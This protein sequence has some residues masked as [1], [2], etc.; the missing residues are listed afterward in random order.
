[1]P[2]RL[3]IFPLCLLLWLSGAVSAQGDPE[4][5]PLAAQASNLLAYIAVDYA[6]AVQDG[7]IRDQSLY[8]QQRRNLARVLELVHQLPDRPGRAAL[9]RSV[10]ELDGA[11]AEKRGALQVRRRANAAADRVAQLYQ[12]QRSPAQMLPAAGEA[13]A[14]YRK[15]CAACHGARGE[16]RARGPALNDAAR[17]ASF[18]LYDIYNTLDPV[19]DTVHAAAVDRDLSSRQRWALA[20]TVAH[21]AV[22]GAEPPAVE[23]AERYP[24]LVGLPGMATARPVEL[25]RDGAAALLWWRGNPDRVRALEHPLARVDGLLQLAET[26]YRAGDSATAYYRVMLAYRRSYLPRR[27]VLQQRDAPLAAQLAGHW[28]SLREGILGN[29]PEAR[30]MAAFQQLRAGLVQA[31]ARLE[32]AADDRHLHFWAALLFAAAL[33]LGLVLW[34]GLRR[35]RR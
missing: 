13:R 3:S 33:G 31:R 21:L 34:F 5:E 17:M 14:L 2:A 32:P 18:S 27:A 23:L 22:A 16:G 4:R 25:P 24:A 9:E 8:E 12:L 20:V 28:E 35:S 10:L 15:R 19:A 1:M 11:I 6:D 29:A 7:G 30:V 26:A